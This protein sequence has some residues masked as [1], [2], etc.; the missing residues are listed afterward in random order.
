[1][2]GGSAVVLDSDLAEYQMQDARPGTLTRLR[3]HGTYFGFTFNHRSPSGYA[4]LVTEH[5]T[6]R[7]LQASADGGPLPA[8]LR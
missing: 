3:I 8:S 7:F 1:M 5:T 4:V 6:R 2:A